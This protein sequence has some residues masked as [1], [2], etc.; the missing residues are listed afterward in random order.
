MVLKLLKNY[1]MQKIEKRKNNISDFYRYLWVNYCVHL[2]VNCKNSRNK[3]SCIFNKFRSIHHMI[4]HVTRK[5]RSFVRNIRL[6]LKSRLNTIWWAVTNS[7]FEIRPKFKIRIFSFFPVLTSLARIKV[8]FGII[9]FPSRLL[10][11][12]DS[13]MTIR[14]IWYGAFKVHLSQVTGGYVMSLKYSIKYAA[15]YIHYDKLLS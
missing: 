2:N 15:Y 3:W 1:G 9:V 13:F 8:Q 10:I 14:T 12:V 4:Y 5:V 11:T 6:G 7:Q